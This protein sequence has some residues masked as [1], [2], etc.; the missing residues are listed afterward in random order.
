MKEVSIRFLPLTPEQEVLNREMTRRQE[1]RSNYLVP[2]YFMHTKNVPSAEAQAALAGVT[3]A[4][5]ASGQ[6]RKIVNF[7]SQAFG[8]GPYLNP[9]WYVEETLKKQKLQKVAGYGQQLIANNVMQH[10]YQEPW[11]KQ[12]H[13]E[14][15]VL[16]RD[17][18]AWGRDGLLNYIFGLTN[19]EFAASIQSITRIMSEIPTEDLRKAM[20]RRLLRHEVGHMFKLPHSNRPNIEI[21]LGLHCTNICTM[22]QGMSITEWAKQTIE[23]AKRGI[24]FCEDCQRDL[25]Q[26]RNR[27]NPLPSQR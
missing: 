5:L 3:D 24:H 2:I 14:V 12:P 26:E 15:F 21:K 8:Q 9:E 27:F 22:R 10:F 1:L 4:L 11:Q 25:A 17:L 13:W 7:G 16:N 18:T 20:I 19:S 23:E 6:N